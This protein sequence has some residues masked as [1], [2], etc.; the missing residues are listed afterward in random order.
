MTNQQ[1]KS[2]AVKIFP[3][4]K[5][6]GGKRWLVVTGQLPIP[7][8]Y[9]RYVEPFLGGGAVF[10]HMD[11]KRSLLSD[12]NRDLI[13]LYKTIKK[14]PDELYH[15]MTLHNK[16]HGKKYYYEIRNK[17]PDNDI[18][19]AAKFLYLNRTCWNGLYRVNLNGVFNVP[20]GTKTSV[21]F[22]TDDFRV[23]SKRLS[24]AKIVCS[25]FEPIIDQCEADDFLF[26]DP[27]YT[28]QH[29][30][31]NFR[32]YNERIFSWDDQ[33]RLRDA[34]LRGESRGVKIAVTNGDHPSIRKLYSGIG[35]YI[36]LH[37]HSRLAGDPTKRRKTSEAIFAINY[38]V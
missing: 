18:E 12:I 17:T 32:K 14:Y 26:V 30:Y 29:N 11:S 31:N 5:W 2:P 36:Q 24:R 20:I 6:P 10:F 38:N 15:L 34:V 19:N 37:R 3:I 16:R 1:S 21:I 23:I 35:T 7:S 13:N 8:T 27:P 25:D 33:I 4:L 28:V 9:L 22:D